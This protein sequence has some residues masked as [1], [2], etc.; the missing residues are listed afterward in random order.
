MSILRQALMKERTE[1]LA[2]H[3]GARIAT[4]KNVVPVVRKMIGIERTREKR[5]DELCALGGRAIDQ[6]RFDGVGRRNAPGEIDIRPP[7]EPC[8]IHVRRGLNTLFLPRRGKSRIDRGRLH[9]RRGRGHRD[10]H[11]SGCMC[12]AR[13]R[14]SRATGEEYQW[15][16]T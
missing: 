10:P 2:V 12:G 13:R 4:E 6:E 11:W 3:I 9:E 14:V 16:K 15:E 5:V 7:N 8:V 1:A